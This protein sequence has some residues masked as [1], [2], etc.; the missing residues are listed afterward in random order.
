MYDHVLVGT[1]GS[2]TA[3]RAVESAARLAHAH[4]A[5]LTIAHAFGP[6]GDLDIDPSLIPDE[7][8]WLRSPGTAAEVLVNAAVDLAQAV[9]CGALSVDARAEVG[10]PLSVMR[11]LMRELQPDAVVVGNADARRSIARRGL[12]AAL[13]RRTHADIVIVDTSGVGGAGRAR[14]SAA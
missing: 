10:S 7:L 8:A 6:K 11:S 13:A 9:A 4:Q 5:H 12:G 2:I 14:R 3:S 1:D